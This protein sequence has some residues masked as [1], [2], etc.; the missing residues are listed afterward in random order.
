MQ[1]I[2]VAI[3]YFDICSSKLK[4]SNQIKTKYAFIKNLFNEAPKAIGIID[5]NSVI[6]VYQMAMQ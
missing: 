6:H 1:S 4:E 3:E 2:D 5:F